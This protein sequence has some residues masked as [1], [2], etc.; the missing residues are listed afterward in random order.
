MVHKLDS[1]LIEMKQ[2]NVALEMEE[3]YR[4]AKILQHQILYYFKKTNENQEINDE[5]DQ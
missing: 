5:L 4:M 2:K 1:K 3:E